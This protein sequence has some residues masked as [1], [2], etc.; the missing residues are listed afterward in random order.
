[1]NKT[2][3]MKIL[4]YTYLFLSQAF[5][6]GCKTNELSVDAI[7]K[8]ADT[9][10]PSAF[11][12][13]MQTLLN[14]DNH[15]TQRT[16]LADSLY[17]MAA[18][19]EWIPL[20]FADTAVFLF[21]HKGDANT[22]IRI[23]GDL[24]GWSTTREPQVLLKAF[25]N[26]NLHYGIYKAPTTDTRVDYK[27]RVGSNFVLDPGNK[28]LAWGGFGSNSELA[29]PDYKYSPWTTEK[30]GI[31]KGTL[32]GN[33]AIK[34][35]TLGYNINLKVYVPHNYNPQLQYP[36]LVTTDGHEYSN[37]KLGALPVVADNMIAEKMIEPLIV[38]FV[39]PRDPKTGENK[40]QNEYVANDKF[41][42][43]MTVELIKYLSENYSIS[44]KANKRAILGTSLGG[45]NSAYC[46]IKAPQAYALIGIQ[47][48]AFWVH[49]QIIDRYKNTDK[50]SLKIYMD[51]GNIYDTEAM[52]RNMKTVLDTKN[53]A[54]RY[55]EY[56]EGHS[57]GNWRA[58][59][60]D[61]LLYFF[62]EDLQK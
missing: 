38:V 25:A 28:K 52:A 32:S 34:S 62:G 4:L 53:V 20:V 36:L 10:N 5:M 11:Y 49:P 58:R 21:T 26:T 55:N 37:Y 46:G 42:H 51:T 27:I 16:E 14:D 1:M 9:S 3:T 41:T 23:M 39:D 7:L 61:I 13:Q 47:S 12:H 44:T 54:L 6:F 50:I 22:D 60:D 43:F 40:R 17:A 56:S 35:D 29:L 24:N 57:W 45:L 31:E 18:R 30:S 2:T 48:P 33:I 15:L 8:Q 59:M 19:K